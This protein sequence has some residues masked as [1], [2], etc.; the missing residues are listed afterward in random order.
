MTGWRTARAR[1]TLAALLVSMLPVA[2]CGGDAVL[3]ASDEPLLYLVLNH[4]TPHF[5]ADPQRAF[6]LTAGTPLASDY[7]A[8]SRFE[9]RRRSDG[10]G[11][12][13]KVTGAAGRAPVDF[14]G[15]A[16]HQ[17]NYVLPDSSG[18]AGLGALDLRSGET[19]DIRIETDGVEIRGS[20][21]IPEPFT[22]S[23][24]G[25][26]G[27]TV[28]WPR[29]RGAAGY[30]VEAQGVLAATLQTDT[31]V[32]LP[33]HPGRNPTESIEVRVQALDPQLYRYHASET[34]G[35]SGI[36]RGYGVFGALSRAGG[37]YRPARTVVS[38]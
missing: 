4:R 20:V 32:V 34:A 33:S 28:S 11:F 36:D 23:F 14:A 29:V 6:L 21:S 8:A 13:W 19:Y 35:R 24:G 7:R 37:T 2:G 17:G 30:T 15:A 9:M 31:S 10:R 22:I 1:S 5:A 3:P 16:L 25:P 38:Q 27:R 18:T 12:A 26:D